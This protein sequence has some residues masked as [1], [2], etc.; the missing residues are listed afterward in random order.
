MC[1]IILTCVAVCA[2]TTPWVEANG[3]NPALGLQFLPVSLILSLPPFVSP[4]QSQTYRSYITSPS[5][6]LFVVSNIFFF[7]LRCF[8]F[9]SPS[10]LTCGIN[11]H[12]PLSIIPF[13]SKSSSNC[14][15]SSPLHLLYLPSSTSSSPFIPSSLPYS[16]CFGLVK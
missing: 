3:C 11:F 10:G 8:R 6:F 5:A 9:S 7:Y 2:D 1:V 12:I 4:S 16:C 13:L 14:Q 15:P